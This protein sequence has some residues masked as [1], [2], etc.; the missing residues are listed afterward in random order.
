M[1]LTLEAE[2]FELRL[3]LEKANAETPRLREKVDHLE[4]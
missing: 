3:E 4:K 1:N 2:N